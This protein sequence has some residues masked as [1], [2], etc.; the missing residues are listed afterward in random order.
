VL[1]L[2]TKIKYIWV[3]LKKG[4]KKSEIANSGIIKE[5]DDLC[6]RILLFLLCFKVK[7]LEKIDAE[8]LKNCVGGFIEDCAL[9][10]ALDYFK[11]KDILDYKYEKADCAEFKGINM[12]KIVSIIGSISD[13]IN[14]M[15]DGEYKEPEAT[16]EQL[17]FEKTYRLAGG[18]S[19]IKEKEKHVKF[20][21]ASFEQD[22]FEINLEETIDTD[23]D[24]AE[25]GD[26]LNNLDS[27]Y[28][29]LDMVCE[30]L[31]KNS[32]F[33]QLYETVPHKLKAI[34]NPKE[35]EILY[36][37]YMKMDMELLLKIAEYC[38]ESS[39]N[40]KSVVNYFEQTALGLADDGITTLEQYGKYLEDARKVVD[41]EEKIRKMFALGEKKLSSKERNLIKTWALEYNHSDEMLI[42]GYRIALEK[43][44]ATIPYI[45]AIYLNWHEKGFK[46]VEDVKNEFKSK[47]DEGNNNAKQVP[48]G[49]NAEHVFDK[50]ARNARKLL[51]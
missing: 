3:K 12:D 35:L 18:V 29:T 50:M 25:H 9:L 49:Y 44:K 11:E 8:V 38:G 2:E 42:E 17:E 27:A 51:E 14:N 28:A 31:E 45:N 10:D 37:L 43:D 16:Q 22:K 26:D 30:E 5:A 19:I 33:R 32:K 34:I 36:N 23:I 15:T 1:L 13:D 24:V 7:D 40:P 47:K 6:A 39:T 48:A 46:T 21:K 20:E 4:L 41:Y